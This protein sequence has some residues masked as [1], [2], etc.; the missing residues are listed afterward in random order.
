MQRFLRQPCNPTY[1]ARKSKK[2]SQDG[3]RRDPAG[4]SKQ[5]RLSAVVPHL[6]PLFGIKVHEHSY[7]GVWS[8]QNS[9]LKSKLP[10]L[11]KAISAQTPCEDMCIET[12]GDIERS[13]DYASSTIRLK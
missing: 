11:Y 12:Y 9:P 1:N 2:I 7:K 6:S 10:V 4:C 8:R 5:S 3:E 13:Y